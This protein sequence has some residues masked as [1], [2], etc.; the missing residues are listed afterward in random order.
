MVNACISVIIPVYNV[1]KYLPRCLDSVLSQS[2]E[3]FEIIAI[4]D[5]SQDGS[6]QVLQMYAQRDDRIKPIFKTNGGV[7]SARNAGLDSAQGEY[8]FFLDGDD[9]IESNTFETLLKFSHGFDIV[10]GAYI[11]SY[12]DGR[13]QIPKAENFMDAEIDHT[14]KMISSYFFA[15]IQESGCNKLYKKT[16][17]GDLRFNESLAVAEDSEFVYG[18]LHR[19]KNIRMLKEITYHYYMRE[20]SCMHTVI[21][22]K[23]FGIL[24]LRDRQFKEI[25]ENKKLYKAFVFRYAKD[26]F[27]LIHGIL[28]DSSK[29][30]TEQLPMLRERVL[31]EKMRIFS[32]SQLN[33]R[34][35]LGVL[36]L[37]L[38]PKQFYK[39]YSR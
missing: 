36:L 3:N 15:Q 23:H 12:Y 31:R 21:G 38:C 26:I 24:A 18:V 9:W 35:K 2:Y 19:A 4:D 20:D 8:V 32:S 6:A 10:Q 5:G 22:D 7:S 28:H 37:W 29:K 39:I 16:V 11:E 13:E 27:F 33:S 17:I 30:F 14:E 34:F 25:K 1:G